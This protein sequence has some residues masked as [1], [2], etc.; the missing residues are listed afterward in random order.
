MKPE[1][2]SAR[3]P[4]LW[5]GLLGAVLTVAYWPGLR[6]PFVFDDLPSLAQNA[7]LASLSRAW[8]PPAGGLTVSGRPLLNFSF[9]LNHAFGGDQVLGYHVANLAIHFAAALLLFGLVRRTLAAR[10]DAD[11]IAGAT[12][13]LWA[14]HPLQTESVTYTVQRAESLAGLFIL[15]TL[16]AALRA[17]TSARP[18]L[19]ATLAVGASCAGAATKETAVVAPLLILLYDRTFADGSFVAAIAARRRF[20]LGLLSSWV[21]L[22]ALVVSAHSR[23]G[24]AGTAG[25]VSS[26]QYAALQLSAIAHY[27]RLVFWP[28][29]LAFDYGPFQSVDVAAVLPGAIFTVGAIA[30]TGWLLWRRPPLGFLGASYFILL[31]PSS[32][33]VPVV[34][35]VAAEHRVYLALAPLLLAIVLAG[36]RWLP[37]PVAL[38]AAAV[39]ALACARLTWQRNRVYATPIGLWSDAAAAC[40]T[41]PRAHLNLGEQLARTGRTRE[42][43]ACFESALQLQ[44]N[45]VTALYDLGTAL[46]SDRRPRDAIAPLRHALDLEPDHAEAA[47][48]LGNAHAALGEHTDAVRAFTWSLRTRPDRAAAHFNLANSLLALDRLPAAIDHLRRAVALAP[49][50]ADAHFNLANALFQS[51]HPELAIPEYEAVL[52]LNPS[53]ADAATNLRLARASARENP[54]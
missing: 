48:N 28:S 3:V 31:A 9:A 46:I 4:W 26:G 45:Y 2:P 54:R 36:A 1:R 13:L 21:L 20:Y 27:V 44:P 10:P 43:I 50:H 16:Y 18:R 22:A 53:D 41:N 23:G 39:A 6:T 19:W 47:Y 8:S 32:S 33:V 25:P 40:P 7:T 17:R 29:P 38:V 14:L 49:D 35:Q 24:T 37:R 11:W 15:A 51:G 5:A 12:T 42:A 34:T 52:R 30:A